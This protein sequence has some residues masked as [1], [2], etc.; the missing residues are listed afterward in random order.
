MSNPSISAKDRLSDTEQLN[1]LLQQDRKLVDEIN[2]QRGRQRS[3]IDSERDAIE[4]RIGSIA[5]KYGSR[6]LG[7]ELISVINNEPI[8]IY[9]E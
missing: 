8:P 2:S 7:P 1:D 4:R 6:Q 3:V 5:Q 9:V